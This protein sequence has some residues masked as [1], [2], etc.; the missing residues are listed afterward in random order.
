[1]ALGDIGAPSAPVAWLHKGWSALSD[2]AHNAM[3]HFSHGDD[4]QVQSA[5]E[6]ADKVVDVAGPAR[7]GIVAVDVV[8]HEDSIEARFEVPGMSKEDLHVEVLGGQIVVSGEKRMSTSR[9]QGGCLITERAFGRFK[10]TISV[11]VDVLGGEATAEYVD[12]VLAVRLP[13]N[14]DT[15]Q[16]AVPVN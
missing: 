7:W 4:E 13:K 8:D 5:D 14:P 11:P 2:Y 6:S 15:V 1:M 12:G 9:E 3:T 16:R 10:R